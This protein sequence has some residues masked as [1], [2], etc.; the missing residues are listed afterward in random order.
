MLVATMK[1]FN[2]LTLKEAEN[3]NR[4]NQIQLLDSTIHYVYEM[5]RAVRNQ[6]IST[7]DNNN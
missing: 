7:P 3:T 1:G 5:L 4:D 6:F 2:S